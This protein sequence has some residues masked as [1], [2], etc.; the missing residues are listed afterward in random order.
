MVEAP[1]LKLPDGSTYA[2][3][4]IN[5][6]LPPTRCT[7]VRVYGVD[8]STIPNAARYE[9]ETI[10]TGG[11]RPEGTWSNGALTVTTPPTPAA[12][13]TPSAEQHQ[14]QP[15]RRA[16]QL[17]NRIAVDVNGKVLIRIGITLLEIRPDGDTVRLVVA[18][19]DSATTSALTS[20]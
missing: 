16:L 17:A 15:T 14:T 7:G 13:A 11:L 4:F 6:S 5:L 10:Q 2:C 8:A 19:A 20:R 1:L 3:R 12:A 9:G 18:V